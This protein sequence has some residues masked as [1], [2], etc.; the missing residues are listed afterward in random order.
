MKMKKDCKKLYPCKRKVVLKKPPRLLEIS[1]VAFHE[2]F[3]HEEENE[4]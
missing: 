1:L 3:K 2:P 4:N